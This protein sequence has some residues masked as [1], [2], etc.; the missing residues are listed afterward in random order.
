MGVSPVNW[1]NF[2]H[3]MNQMLSKD[4]FA[5]PSSPEDHEFP[6]GGRS[7][8]IFSFSVFGMMYIH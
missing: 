5:D 1:D 2:A 7:H 3:Y 6:A 4:G 8:V